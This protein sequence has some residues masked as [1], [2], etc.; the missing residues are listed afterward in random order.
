V[1]ILVEKEYFEGGHFVGPMNPMVT[2]STTPQKIVDKQRVSPSTSLPIPTLIEIATPSIT[3]RILFLSGL[4]LV[5][6]FLLPSPYFYAH[7]SPSNLKHEPN[8]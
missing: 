4:S 2:K 8:D 6:P 3:H 7:D 1:T 5:F